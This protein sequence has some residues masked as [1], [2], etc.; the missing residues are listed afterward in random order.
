[1]DDKSHYVWAY[2]MKHKDEVFSKFL[3][4]KNMVEQM[5]NY[6]LKTLRTDSDSEYTSSEFQRF[7][8]QASIRHELTIPKTPEQN[9]IAERLNRMLVKATRS[10]VIEAELPRKFWAE[11]LSTAVYLKNRSFTST[12]PKSTQFQEWSREKPNIENLRVS[13]C[14][15]YRH[16]PKDERS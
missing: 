9:G 8:K 1:M 11:G 5:S 4:W 14:V 2:F 15:A 3:E 7:L 6:H 16:I 10:M 12:V 13:G